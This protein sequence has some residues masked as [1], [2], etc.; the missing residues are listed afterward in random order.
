MAAAVIL[1][2]GIFVPGMDSVFGEDRKLPIYS[3]DTNEK[4]VAISFDCAWG[5]EHTKPILD[6]LDQYDVKTTFFMVK[7]W[8]EKFPEDVLEIYNRGHEIGNHSSTHPNMSKLSVDDI[9]KELQG[10]EEAITNITGQRPTVFRPPFGA[11]SN[12]LIETCKVNGYHVIQWDVDSL[13]WKDLTAEQIV[14]RVTRNV[15]TGSIILFHNNAEHV[16]E[17]LPAILSKLQTEGYKIVPVSQL[18]IKENYHMDHAGK[19]LAD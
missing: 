1:L 16:E 17:Y 18:I 2:I 14:D 6:I 3:V 8:A 13:D 11:Y 19:Q 4:E 15:S 7:F 12:I 10:A 5:N 9:K